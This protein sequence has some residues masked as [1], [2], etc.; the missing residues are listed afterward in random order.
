MNVNINIEDLL[1][2]IDDEEYEEPA[3]ESDSEPSGEETKQAIADYRSQEFLNGY[4]QALID[5]MNSRISEEMRME[6]LVTFQESHLQLSEEELEGWLQRCRINDFRKILPLLE[7]LPSIAENLA[8]KIILSQA[9]WDPCLER[10]VQK[11]AP[12]ERVFRCFILRLN[13]RGSKRWCQHFVDY[14]PKLDYDMQMRLLRANQRSRMLPR[15]LCLGT[16]S[17]D[18]LTICFELEKEFRTIDDKEWKSLWEIA[19]TNEDEKLSVWRVI[20]KSLGNI[21]LNDVELMVEISPPVIRSLVNKILH[22]FDQPNQFVIDVIVKLAQYDVLNFS[23]TSTEQMLWL[24]M[25]NCDKKNY[26]NEEVDFN[27]F[28]CN[29]PKH[30]CWIYT[31]HHLHPAHIISIDLIFTQVVIRKHRFKYR[32]YFPTKETALENLLNECNFNQLLQCLND[33]L[34]YFW[35]LIHGNIAFSLSAYD[36]RLTQ[37]HLID[38]FIEYA[39]GTRIVQFTLKDTWF[40]SASLLQAQ[41]N[42]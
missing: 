23:L 33:G 27:L 15:I 6:L 26:W 9:S 22:C 30:M 16:F 14:F 21:I 36:K 35:N 29:D 17:K 20:A 38:M 10:I 18:L 41:N 24:L 34:T 1:Q 2:N 40:E 31:R 39:F 3:S 4:K 42:I 13:K 8:A 19:E 7:K 28:P 32:Q 37:K 5:V 12:S 25:P 11:F